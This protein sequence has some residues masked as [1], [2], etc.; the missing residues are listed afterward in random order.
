LEIGNWQSE[1]S[2]RF[3]VTRVLAAA[4]AKL[5]KL[6]PFRGR[7]FVLGSDVVA[8]FA[9]R[10]LKYDVVARHNSTLQIL[11]SRSLSRSLVSDLLLISVFF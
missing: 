7:F 9:I 3:L 5:T 8:A 11:Y 4:P 6:Q 10:A 1:M 2:L